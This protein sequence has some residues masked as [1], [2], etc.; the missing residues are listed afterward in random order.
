MKTSRA[1]MWAGGA[2]CASLITALIAAFPQTA[3]AQTD[4][5][6]PSFGPALPGIC[7]L[8]KKEA[9][10]GSASS[11]AV[12]A[13][14]KAAEQALA[15]AAAQQQAGFTARR[16]Q[17]AMLQGKLSPADYARHLADI[18][19]DERTAV[20]T[21]TR[22]AAL[23]ASEAAKARAGGEQRMTQALISVVTAKKCSLI[24]ERDATYG[25]NYA[26]DITPDVIRAMQ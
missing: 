9:L 19:T 25:W 22:Q 15:T 1:A 8:A 18:D 17:L 16:G 10:T 24:V 14:I 11:R 6:G 12:E 21:R 26:M 3:G 7:L 2:A 5:R 4:A 13:R 23:I 20:A